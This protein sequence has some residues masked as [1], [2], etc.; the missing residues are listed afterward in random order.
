[1]H[2]CTA[3][4]PGSLEV[5]PFSTSHLCPDRQCDTTLLSKLTCLVLT[6]AKALVSDLTATTHIPLRI[7]QI[8]HDEKV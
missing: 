4:I 6:L 3:T 2:H 7:V 5:E 1:M 8:Y